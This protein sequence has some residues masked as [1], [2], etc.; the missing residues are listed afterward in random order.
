MKVLLHSHFPAGHCL[1]MQAVAHALVARGH[2]VRWLT[3]PSSLRHISPTAATP[4]PTSSLTDLD[5]PLIATNNT[6]LLDGDYTHLE[7][8]V[9]S[10]VEDYRRALQGFDADVFLVDVWPHGVRALRELGE[11]PIWA[12]LGV[13]PMY[14]GNWDGPFAV[15]GEEPPVGWLAWLW[16]GMKQTVRRF[17]VLPW[18]LKSIIDKQRR[19]LGLPP[20]SYGEAVELFWYSPHL[21]IQASSPTLEFQQKPQSVQGVEFVGPLVMPVKTQTDQLPEWWPRVVAHPRVI[22]ITQGT[23]AMD[24]ASLIMPSIQALAGDS[25]NLLVVASPH[26]KEIEAQLG[27]FDNVL[28]ATWLPYSTL[29]PQLSLLIT[30]GGYGSITQALSHRVPLLCAGQTEDKRDTAARVSWAGVGIDLKTDGP[31]TRQVQEAAETIL[32]DESYRLNAAKLGDELN[33]LGGAERACDLL[34][35]LAEAHG[36]R[37]G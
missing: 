5:D 28:F 7:G 6:G 31:S 16:N 23:L 37:R 10:Q 15:S 3:Y 12:T 27:S 35:E 9:L 26:A 11:G 2:S 34:E 29:L 25:R 18:M 1:P 4:I 36:K 17:L 32:G 33:G 14:T 19:D 22:G 13:I 30:N 8:R 21:H 24:P 20:L